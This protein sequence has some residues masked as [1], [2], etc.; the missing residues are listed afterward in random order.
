MNANNVSTDILE[1]R[2]AEQR[3]QLHQ[4]VAALKG[5]VHQRL[6]VKS[7]AREYI[8]PASAIAA[9]LGLLIGYAGTGIFYHD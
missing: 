4:S 7:N 9:A 1:L 6:D 3:Q 2:A 5:A 8:V